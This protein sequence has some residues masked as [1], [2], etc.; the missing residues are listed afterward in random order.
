MQ[1]KQE[2]GISLIALIIAI[3]AVIAVI[4]VI[5]IVVKHNSNANSDNVNQAEFKGLDNLPSS[6]GEMYRSYAGFG[7]IVQT[8]D[9]TLYIKE[10]N[11]VNIGDKKILEQNLYYKVQKSKQQVMFALDTN[12]K[13]FY[14][15]YK[16]GTLEKISIEENFSSKDNPFTITSLPSVSLPKDTNITGA[17]IINNEISIQDSTGKTFTIYKIPTD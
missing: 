13:I 16:D 8:G 17:S 12:D 15:I 7:L 9:K 3:V 2:K 11:D 10:A 14:V 6:N 4:F 1:K 5:T